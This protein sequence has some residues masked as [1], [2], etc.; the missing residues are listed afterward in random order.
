M[1]PVDVMF[2]IAALLALGLLVFALI[3]KPTRPG[4][5]PRRSRNAFER[6]DTPEHSQAGEEDAALPADPESERRDRR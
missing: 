1:D 3:R 2:V 4:P 6:W 5:P